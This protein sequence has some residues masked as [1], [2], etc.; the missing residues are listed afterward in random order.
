MKDVI[1]KNCGFSIDYHF[2]I[3][4]ECPFVFVTGLENVKEKTVF[5][6]VEETNDNL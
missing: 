3:T 6:P 4:N 2:W 1:C 5:E